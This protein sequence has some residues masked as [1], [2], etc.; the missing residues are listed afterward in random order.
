MADLSDKAR[1]IL[2]F[3]A[4]HSLTSGEEVREVVLDDGAGHKADHEGVEALE[5]AGLIEAD[6]A[7][8][9][10]TPAGQEV[11]TKLLSAIR[12]VSA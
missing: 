8:G 9:R 5:R 12:G 7:R 11:L 6:G 2:A 1:S 3:A 10:F 4:Y